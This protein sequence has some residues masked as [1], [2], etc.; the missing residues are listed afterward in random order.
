[1]HYVNCSVNS[2]LRKSG[3]CKSV[4]PWIT[5]LPQH[6]PLSILSGLQIHFCVIIRETRH[7]AQ[8]YVTLRTLVDRGLSLA[9]R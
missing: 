4:A 9:V 1:M 2:S 3:C 7:H 6:T 5:I 8:A